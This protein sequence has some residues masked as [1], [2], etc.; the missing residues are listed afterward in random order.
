MKCKCNNFSQFKLKLL[1]LLVLGIT[2]G[3]TTSEWTFSAFRNPFHT[4]YQEK[5]RTKRWEFLKKDID[6]FLYFCKYYNLKNQT[7][8]DFT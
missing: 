7:Q 8:W 1:T 3:R 5:F 4:Y 2:V 6:L